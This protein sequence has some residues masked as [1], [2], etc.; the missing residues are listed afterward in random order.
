[1]ARSPRRL[2]RRLTLGGAIVG[3][4]GLLLAVALTPA[5]PASVPDGARTAAAQDLPASPAASCLGLLS[6]VLGQERLRD[7]AS[8]LVLTQLLGFPPGAAFSNLAQMPA[9]SLECIAIIAILIGLILP[10][11]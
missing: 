4:V 10:G 5:A 7:D 11:A 1:M 6:A 8:A 2:P 3:A 9:D